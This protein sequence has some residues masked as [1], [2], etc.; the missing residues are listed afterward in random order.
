MKIITKIGACSARKKAIGMQFVADG[1]KCALGGT[2]GL[3]GD[4]AIVSDEEL[5]G[6]LV[7]GESF[8]KSGCKLCG[9]KHAFRCGACGRVVCYDGAAKRGYA[10]PACG[11]VADVPASVGDAIPTTSA[12]SRGGATGGT[13]RLSQ[14][15]EVK[16][17]L[18]DNGTLS[19]IIVGVGWDPAEYGE[20]MDVDS[21]VIVAGCNGYETVYFGNLTHPSGC[22]EHHGDN[23]TG[24]SVGG[25]G[26]DEN[27]TV[28][29]NKVPK[30]RD[31]LIF[32]LNIYDCVDR[33]Q[34][35]ADVNNMYITL[36]D[37]ATRRPLI[38]YRLDPAYADDTAIVIGAVYRRGDEWSFKA[39]GKGSCAAD[40]DD[41]AAEAVNKY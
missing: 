18:P 20:R 13:V 17:A 38:E 33:N 9:N 8:K 39:I 37:P 34:T 15:Q 26:D 28:Y 23:L 29:L 19:K 25:N 1:A 11:A 30:D 2:Y 16:I 27:I 7:V 32:V 21:S 22:V 5:S 24:E 36:Y 3:S 35:L 4:T 31:K 6:T 41:L 12:A 40:I 14:G 10:C